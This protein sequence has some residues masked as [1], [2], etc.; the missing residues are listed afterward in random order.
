LE[1]VTIF[2]AGVDATTNTDNIDVGGDA[3]DPLK[4]IIFKMSGARARSGTA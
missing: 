2:G 4:R 1:D 3:G